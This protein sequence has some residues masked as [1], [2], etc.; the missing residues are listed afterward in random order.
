[1][2]ISAFLEVEELGYMPKLYFRYGTMNSSKTAQALMIK[3]NYEQQGK[4]VALLKPAVDDRYGPDVVKSRIG[5]ESKAIAISSTKNIYEFYIRNEYQNYYPDK[6]R[7]DVI[8]VDEAQF[9]TAEQVDQLK[10]LSNDF[11][12]ILCFGLKTDSQ[13]HLFEGSK[14]LIE[15]ANSL[16]EI[17][18]VCKCG[19]KAEISARIHNGKIVKNGE[20]IQIGG[21]ESYVPM[22]YDCWIHE[23]L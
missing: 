5:L 10:E 6:A 9:L 3:Y 23:R 11:I 12:P 14:R 20:Q 7:P 4:S 15:L 17:K 19:K 22:C 1:M 8:I 2:E 21:N 13:T 18:T 16:V